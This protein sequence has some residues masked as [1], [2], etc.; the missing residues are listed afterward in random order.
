[1]S[2]ANDRRPAHDRG[3]TG[4]GGRGGRGRGGRSRRSGCGCGGGCGRRGGRL[5]GS[6]GATQLG[7][8]ERREVTLDVAA[9][10]IVA[11]PGEG[12]LERL[13][14]RGAVADLVAGG[15]ADPGLVAAGVHRV[16]ALAVEVTG[17]CPVLV[18][19]LGED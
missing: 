16:R 18:G 7:G 2:L 13:V 12:D 5:I 14:E 6:Y 4:G 1:M 3:E 8:R 11:R 9:Q 10:Q 19:V 15:G 17:A